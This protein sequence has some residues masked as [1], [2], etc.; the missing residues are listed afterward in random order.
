M[1][2]GAG[3]ASD[4]FSRTDA[5]PSERMGSIE[6]P[7]P[8]IVTSL[9][10]SP[11]NSATP[12]S[13]STIPDLPPQDMIYS[14][15]D[16][17]FKHCNTWCPILERQTTFGIFFGSTS[18]NEAD[19]VLLHAIVATTLRFFKDPRL[20][21]QMKAHY[22]AT[23]RRIVQTYVMEHV[24]IPALRALVI[25]TL[26]ELGTSNGPKGWNLLSLLTQN[27]KQLGLCDE[28]SVYLLADAEDV[29]RTGSMRRVV[30]GRPD[31]WIEDEGR[32]RLAWMVYLL[33]RYSTVATTTFDFMI[34]DRRMKRFL[35]CSYDLFSRNVP[36]ETRPP[37]KLTVDPADL[38]AYANA[39]NS[40]SLGSFSYHCEILRILS[41]VHNFLKQ[42]LDVSSP[43]DMAG[44]RNKYQLLDAALDR[45]LQGLP[46]E[47]SRISALCHSDP[48]SRV[49]NWFMLHS[50]YVTAVI[51]LHSLAA[52]PTIRTELFVPSHYAMQRCM[53]AV[54]SLRDISQDVF[55]ANG[56][57]LLGPP[58]A[59]SLWVAA[60]LLIVHASTT[61]SPVDE[62]IEFFMDTLGYVG[63]YWEV[64]NN[65]ARIL[66]RVVSRGQQGDVSFGAMRR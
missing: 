48:A 27:V 23:S 16:L 64:A 20:T 38:N 34:E 46:S 41:E 17:Y 15:V 25:I 26:D 47:Y 36:R 32:R 22:H 54:Q 35:P 29:P 28:S 57:D 55:E 49:A 40:E 8:G 11:A 53:S 30:A 10:Y 56:L 4:S 44:W 52:Y 60:R 59:F 45:W 12:R 39:A 5:A 58:F 37:S 19:R 42:P 1:T 65:Y 3:A 24:S 14:L 18:L 50:A 66:K 31:S 6:M 2:P 43:S 63:Q 33:D 7:Q 13:L 51:R 21:S 61:G 62:K 9:P